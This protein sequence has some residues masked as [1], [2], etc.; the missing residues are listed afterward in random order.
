MNTGGIRILTLIAALFASPAQA[1]D[2]DL[3][4]VLAVDGSGS[5]STREYKL[6]LAGYAAAL[7]DSAVQSAA[8]SGPIGKVAV[9]MMVWS[10]AAFQKFET[11][12]HIIGSPADAERFA[13]TVETFHEH[14]GRNYGLGGG[15][16]GIGSGVDYAMKMLDENGITATRQVI[17]VSGDG[18]ETDPWF[19]KAIMM[20][21]AR[22]KAA[23][24]GIMI[25]GLA[26]LN[27]FK[28]LDDYYRE[29]V[30]TG[31]GSFVIEAVD[32]DAFAAAIQLKLWL[33]FATP[34]AALPQAPREAANRYTTNGLKH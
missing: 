9:A 4:I 32:F 27:D 10:D 28:K 3:E 13:R 12:W 33:E 26:I 2:V 25:N 23:A 19:A 1:Q 31:S 14:S 7:R 20:P 5:I 22:R 30:I 16:T 15:G 34:V 18:I 24:R 6:Q 11:D 21:E 17:D 8:V 29:N